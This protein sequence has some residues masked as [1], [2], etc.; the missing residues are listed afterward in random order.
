M[1]G[2]E[3]KE[4]RLVN[5][6]F[7]IQCRVR[8]AF[9][10]LSICQSLCQSQS[11]RAQRKTVSPFIVSSLATPSSFASLPISRNSRV[12]NIKTFP[13]FSSFYWGVYAD[14]VVRNGERG[15]E[16]IVIGLSGTDH[17]ISPHFS[18]FLQIKR[19][20]N[21]INWFN[22]ST[23]FQVSRRNGSTFKI[24]NGILDD[25]IVK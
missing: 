25:S 22:N 13:W 8:A 10:F 20:K 9:S 4:K 21:R 5:Y 17:W 2:I 15:F 6:N 1:R 14:F 19:F 7:L 24:P 11:P 18:S 23:K 3:L 12:V 16:M